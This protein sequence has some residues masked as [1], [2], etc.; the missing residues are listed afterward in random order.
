MRGKPNEAPR[1]CQGVCNPLLGVIRF[2]HL[3]LCIREVSRR[4][5]VDRRYLTLFIYLFICNT[6]HSVFFP[7]LCLILKN[8]FLA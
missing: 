5:I 1:E 2:K 7:K 3:T 4:V 6:V 8:R